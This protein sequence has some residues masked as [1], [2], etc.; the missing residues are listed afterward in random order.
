MM[1]KGL[2]RVALAHLNKLAVAAMA[3]CHATR[4]DVSF[5]GSGWLVQA[6]PQSD[7]ALLMAEPLPPD[8]AEVI[9]AHIASQRSGSSRGV[10]LMTALAMLDPN[11]QAAN[12]LAQLEWA[13]L[14]NRAAGLSLSG[15][16]AS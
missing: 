2:N 15:D 10:L 12:I 13:R 5:D 16:Q 6:V 9:A 14:E 1:T 8:S 11:Q 4:L 7:L 3:R